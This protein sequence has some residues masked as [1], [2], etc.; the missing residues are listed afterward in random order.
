M[1]FS[2]QILRLSGFQVV[3][4]SAGFISLGEKLWYKNLP[5]SLRSSANG[6]RDSIH[7]SVLCALL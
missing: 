3:N 6:S 4:Y 5:P 1:H 2:P 7:L